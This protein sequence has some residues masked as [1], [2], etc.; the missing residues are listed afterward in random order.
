MVQSPRN[1]LPH[2]VPAPVGP[3]EAR[4]LKLSGLLDL[5]KSSSTGVARPKMVTD[6]RSLFFLVVCIFRRC[7]GSR[8]EPSFDDANHLP[9]SKRSFG[10]RLVDAFLHLLQDLLDL[11]FR[12][13]GGLVGGT[14]DEA[15]D[16]WASTLGARTRRSFPFLT[17]T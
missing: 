12:R 17:S 15:G 14:A 16:S 2:P 3:S 11:A 7:H 9:I 4:G 8:T 6:T 5:A 10:T 1:R 13:W